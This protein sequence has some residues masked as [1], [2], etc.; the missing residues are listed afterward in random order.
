MN[1]KQM[2][3]KFSTPIAIIVAGAL[4][5][6]GLIISNSSS[7]PK[8]PREVDLLTELTKNKVVRDLGIKEKDLATCI[9]SEAT[10]AKVAA[11]AQLAQTAGL[12][13]TPHMIVLMQDGTQFPIFGAMPKEIIEEALR[14]AS[15]I[16]EQLEMIVDEIPEHFINDDD[17]VFGNPETAL[18]TIFEY[19]DIQCVFCKR[20]HPVLTELLNE[21]KIA[22]VYRHAPFQ[23][24]AYEKAIAAECVASFAGSEGF[25]VYLNELMKE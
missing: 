17:H 21:G 18:A 8:P 1:T 22:W 25:K 14:T 2:L 13:G 12:R 6:I 24:N 15:P 23:A 20:I 3:E 16:P 9:T 11:D 5:G 19:S 4:I 10:A 7:S